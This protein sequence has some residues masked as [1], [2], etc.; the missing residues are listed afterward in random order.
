VDYSNEQEIIFLILGG[1]MEDTGSNENPRGMRQPE[2][3]GVDTEFVSSEGDAKR[4]AGDIDTGVSED[5]Q[6]FGRAQ[7]TDIDEETRQD[8]IN[9]ISKALDET[10]NE[11]SS[12]TLDKDSAL[13]K[14]TKN[15][16]ERL[17][18]LRNTGLDNFEDARRNADN[19]LN[20]L[21]EEIQR[22][23]K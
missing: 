9:R 11:I 13:N 21:R 1:L 4:I 7:F 23:A 14:K 10:R 8:H 6:T 3:D 2:Y 12:L 17:T 20:E 5:W 16:E 18:Q 19:A 22:V 15:L